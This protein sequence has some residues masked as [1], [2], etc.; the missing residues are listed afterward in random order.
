MVERRDVI[1]GGLAAGLAALL[2]DAAAQGAQTTQ[3][4][5]QTDDDAMTAKA[6]DA[7][8]VMIEHRHE[9]QDIRQIRSQ[10]RTFLKANQKFPDFIDVGIDVWER[11]HDWHVKNRQ[12]LTVVRTNDGLYSMPFMATTLLLRPEQTAGYISWGYDVR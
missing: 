3:R 1:G 12:P 10:Q 6:V 7:L 9:S 4:T 5:V 2:G 8:R 11:L